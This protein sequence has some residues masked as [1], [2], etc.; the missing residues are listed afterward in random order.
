MQSGG[1][2]RLV[3]DG[4]VMGDQFAAERG[5]RRAAACAAAHLGRDDRPAEAAVQ[6]VDQRPGA[7]VRNALRP[8]GGRDRAERTDLFEQSY[9]PR[10]DAS[11]RVDVDAETQ[12]DHGESSPAGGK[13]CRGI[14][15]R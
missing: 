9:L 2:L 15:A 13:L 11:V 14:V 10:P 3:L 8:P 6:L 4:A 12:A 1:L 7:L 5:Q